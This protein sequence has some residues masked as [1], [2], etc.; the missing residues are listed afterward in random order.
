ML[1][2]FEPGTVV[3]NLQSTDKFAAIHE[4]VGRAAVFANGEQ[5]AAVEN[6]VVRREHIQT[7][8]I[9]HGVAAAHGQTDGVSEVTIALGISRTGINYHSVDG[10]PVRL[11]FVLATPPDN[12]R[13]YLTALSGICRLSKRQFFS[14]L[15]TR[16]MTEQELQQHI[17]QAF[18]AEVERSSVQSGGANSTGPK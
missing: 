8:G 1:R 16:D 10:E 5:R 4:V 9:G 18:Q 13:D 3:D 6:A 17:C 11:L 7:T 14:E 2:C 12:H 15:L